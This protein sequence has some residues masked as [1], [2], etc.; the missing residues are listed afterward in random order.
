MTPKTYFL[1]GVA[2]GAGV[3]LAASAINNAAMALL[4]VLAVLFGGYALGRAHTAMEQQ[5]PSQNEEDLI[6][7]PGR[8]TPM[9]HE[10]EKD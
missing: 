10:H 2:F 3:T 9:E 7:I 1:T 6:M 5:T 4:V 8:D